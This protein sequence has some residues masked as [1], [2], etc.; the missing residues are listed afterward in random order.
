MTAKRPDELEEYDI[1][2]LVCGEIFN[3]PNLVNLVIRFL[4]QSHLVLNTFGI[5]S[6]NLESPRGG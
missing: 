3:D 5:S 1:Q 4:K 6:K 2:V